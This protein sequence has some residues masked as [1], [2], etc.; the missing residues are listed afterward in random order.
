MRRTRNR[1]LGVAAGGTLVAGVL[2]PAA[3][4]AP[5]SAAPGSTTFGYT[6]AEQSY[7]VPAGTTGIGHHC[8]RRRRFGH[9]QPR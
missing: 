6:G 9:L 5:A 2:L 4:A 1:I 7:A 3:A 8:G